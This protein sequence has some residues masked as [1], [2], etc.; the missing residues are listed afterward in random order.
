MYGSDGTLQPSIQLGA[1]TGRRRGQSGRSE[2]AGQEPHGFP[3][4]CSS[5]RVSLAT[6]RSASVTGSGTEPSPRVGKRGLGFSFP[7]R[8][9]WN[10]AQ[11]AL[12]PTS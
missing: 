7:V 6:G 5:G 9:V 3:S 2:G 11:R 8:V 12:V 4:L 1:G 10:K